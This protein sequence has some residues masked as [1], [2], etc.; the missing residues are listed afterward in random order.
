VLERSQPSGV[1]EIPILDDPLRENLERFILRFDDPGSPPESRPLL[2]VPIDIRASDPGISFDSPL[3][4]VSERSAPL[5]LRVRL[6]S[7]AGL[8]PL[9]LHYSFI[10][11]TASPVT[12]FVAAPGPLRFEAGETE[13][14]I[15]L[16]ILDDT[17]WEGDEEF[18]VQLRLPLKVFNGKIVG[19][20][21]VRILDNDSIS[22]TARHQFPQVTQFFDVVFGDGR[23]VA[24]G[25]AGSV[26]WSDSGVTWY[27]GSVPTAE[28]L[29]AVSYGR[30][31]Y[32]CAGVDGSVLTSTDGAAWTRTANIRGGAG[33]MRMTFGSGRFLI[34]DEAGVSWTSKDGVAW[35]PSAIPGTAPIRALTYGEGRFVAGGERGALFTTE[36]GIAWTRRELGSRADVRAL[37]HHD[38]QFWGWGNAYSYG[39]LLWSGGGRRW[40]VR[41]VIGLG[42]HLTP[43]VSRDLAVWDGHIYVAHDSGIETVRLEGLRLRTSG[44]GI[45]GDIRALAKGPGRLVAAGIQRPSGAG[46]VLF[47]RGGDLPQ[48]W[49]SPRGILKDVAGGAGVQCV[50]GQPGLFRTTTGEEWHLDSD[51]RS[52]LAGTIV[53]GNGRFIRTMTGTDNTEIEPFQT[54]VDGRRWRPALEPPGDRITALLFNGT[55]F[56][57]LRESGARPW[58]RSVG[59]EVWTEHENPLDI[60]VH[61]LF[62]GEHRFFALGARQEDGRTVQAGRTSP[63][64]RNWESLELPPG[65]EP[66]AGASGNGRLVFA[67]GYIGGMAASEMWS[68]QDVS[69]RNPG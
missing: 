23:F 32:V 67:T 27:A 4:A 12:D 17:A 29:R 68:S 18:I 44:E 15:A 66:Y 33:R 36:D 14:A 7:D 69:Q 62:A 64:G 41:D 6:G 47:N 39:Y 40:Q 50:I 43:N 52:G 2:I 19:E 61:V 45:S 63:D 11:L 54:S 55:S 51:Q 60:S 28:D 22:W 16:S 13:K 21:R 42:Y 34:V 65:P 9:D 56:L 53:Y 26:A 49:V 37:T 5:E 3:V 38:R 24:V 20:C 59:G 58:L 46:P 35:Q 48:D 30:G 25:T 57:A 10:E 1:V 8:A 31:R